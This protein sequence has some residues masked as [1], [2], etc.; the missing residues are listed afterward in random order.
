MC[1]CPAHPEP[2]RPPATRKLQN[3]PSVHEKRGGDQGHRQAEAD[4]FGWFPEQPTEP[5]KG[6]MRMGL[7]AFTGQP[8]QGQPHRKEKEW[9]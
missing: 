9:G 7:A 4:P 6:I 8:L 2:T 5:A 3:I 1:R